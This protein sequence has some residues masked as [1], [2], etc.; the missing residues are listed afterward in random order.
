ME[1][2]DGFLVG[3]DVDFGEAGFEELVGAADGVAAAEGGL[4]RDM[5]EMAAADLG[6]FDIEAFAD[7]IPHPVRSQRV[8]PCRAEFRPPPF[9]MTRCRSS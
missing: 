5:R 6:R 3:F 4:L 8:R 9:T 1:E 7:D 2:V